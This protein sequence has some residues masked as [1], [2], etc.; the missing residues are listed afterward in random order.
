MSPLGRAITTF[1]RATEGLGSPARLRAVLLDDTAEAGDVSRAEIEAVVRAYELG[2]VT[3]SPDRWAAIHRQ[4][5]ADVDPTSAS[6]ALDEWADVLG[7]TWRASTPPPLGIGGLPTRLGS[8]VSPALPP[9]PVDPAGASTTPPAPGR[10]ARLIGAVVAVAVVAAAVIGIGALR[11][12]SGDGPSDRDE[13]A[14][15]TA[16]TARAVVTT[17]T[18]TSAATETHESTTAPAA[19]NPLRAMPWI[20]DTCTDVGTT[21]GRYG[22]TQPDPN[23]I[24]QIECDFTATSGV[25]VAVFMYS[26]TGRDRAYHSWRVGMGLP[27]DTAGSCQSGG[28]ATGTAP[29]PSGYEGPFR[30]TADGP[31]VGRYLCV[32]DPETRTAYLVW[33]RDD[34]QYLGVVAAD[35]LRTAEEW[36]SAHEFEDRV[37]S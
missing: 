16:T 30:A 18:S 35:N 20:P 13:V 19:P 1:L 6:V 24:A 32:V 2:I 23:A 25:E 26:R 29:A 8:P 15:S 36:W 37:W 27:S 4:V 28:A 34:L 7:T 33:Y 12:G 17:S 10:R 11:R 5:V 31:T 21:T 3:L 9:L 22:R 14:R